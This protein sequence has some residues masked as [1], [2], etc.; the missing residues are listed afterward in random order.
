VQRPRRANCVDE[1]RPQALRRHAGDGRLAG[2]HERGQRDERIR[3]TA[4][5]RVP[6]DALARYR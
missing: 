4:E 6:I 1:R 3:N 2:S 5:R